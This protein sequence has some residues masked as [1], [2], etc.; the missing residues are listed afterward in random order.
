MNIRKP[1]Q[2]V[3]AYIFWEGRWCHV[4]VI[5]GYD[6]LQLFGDTVKMLE[7]KLSKKTKISYAA[8]KSSFQ[9]RRPAAAKKGWRE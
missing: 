4:Y 1:K 3:R 7:F 5:S 9:E 6:Q 2:E 8:P